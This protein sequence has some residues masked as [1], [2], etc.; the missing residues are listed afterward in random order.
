MK[1]VENPVA[2]DEFLCWYKE[3]FLRNIADEKRLGTAF[4]E[5]FFPELSDPTLKNWTLDTSAFT[6]IMCYYVD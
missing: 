3:D 6:R 1:L 4:L 2:R 5:R